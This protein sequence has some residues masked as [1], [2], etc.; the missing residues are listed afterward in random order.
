MSQKSTV[1]FLLFI[2]TFIF[3]K[4]TYL[5][6]LGEVENIVSD[7]VLNFITSSNTDL[8]IEIERYANSGYDDV[9]L[10]YSFWNDI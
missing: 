5:P 8:T 6:P 3:A 4:T 1:I 7:D 2:S 9:I 10:G